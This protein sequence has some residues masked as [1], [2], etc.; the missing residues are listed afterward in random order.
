MLPHDPHIASLGHWIVRNW[1][2]EVG[3]V[4]VAGVGKEVVDFVLVEARQLQVEV[5]APEFLKFGAEE[6][7]I[8]IRLL[9]AAIIH[10]PVSFDLGWRQVGRYVDRHLCEAQLLRGQQSGMPADN[11]KSFVDNDGHAEPELFDGR[12]DFVNRALRDLAAIPGVRNRFIDRPPTHFKII[13]PSPTTRL[14]FGIFR[15][16][17]LAL[18]CRTVPLI[19]L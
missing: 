1:R 11:D 3:A 13:H 19:I 18:A 17:R 16:V 9:M 8:P 4:V 2:G 14:D 15:R 7:Q 12:G 10:E 6:V 5:E